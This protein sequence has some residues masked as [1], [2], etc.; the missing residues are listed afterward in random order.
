AAVSFS[1]RLLALRERVPRPAARVRLD[2]KL[3]AV[4][5]QRLKHR[6]QCFGAGSG[7]GLG[8]NSETVVVQPTRPSIDFVGI[9][10]VRG[11]DQV[12]HGGSPQFVPVAAEESALQ[13]VRWGLHPIATRAHMDVGDVK[14]G[15]LR[16]GLT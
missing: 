4:L 9:D 2:L 10:V 16:A 5:N 12:E 11:P 13:R 1:S 3:E 7:L 6:P 15:L 8:D 14:S